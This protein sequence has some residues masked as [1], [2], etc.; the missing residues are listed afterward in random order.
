M[1]FQTP[2]WSWKVLDVANRYPDGIFALGVETYNA[3]N[4]PFAIV[5]KQ[6]V[7]LMGRIH[8]V[9]V[10]WG[11]VYLRDVMAAFGR[12]IRIPEVTIDHE[13]IGNAPDTVFHEANQGERRNWDPTYWEHHRRLVAKA[14]GQLKARQAVVA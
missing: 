11:D 1:V 13:W 8:P 5:S 7:E 4:F 2:D 12:A 9:D 6:A 14:V 3:K 10:F